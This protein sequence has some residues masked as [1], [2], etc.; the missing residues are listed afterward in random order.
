MGRF[1]GG[2]AGIGES[3]YRQSTSSYGRQQLT[4]SRRAIDKDI[5]D[6]ESDLSHVYLPTHYLRQE[7]YSAPTVLLS[8]IRHAITSM[9][10]CRRLVPI[11]SNHNI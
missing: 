6:F 4:A 11:R 2:E 5:Y 3:S 1:R 9:K 10:N 7:G 8:E